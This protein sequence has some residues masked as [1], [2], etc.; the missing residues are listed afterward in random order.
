VLC[1]NGRQVAFGDPA[2]SLGREVLEETYGSELV[3]LDEGDEPL[4]A[5]AVQ[6]HDH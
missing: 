2:S 3:V 1:L 6:H 4:R 5:I